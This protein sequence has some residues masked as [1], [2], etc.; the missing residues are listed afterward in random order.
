VPQGRCLRQSEGGPVGLAPSDC[1]GRLS[2]RWI[3]R[4]PKISP[5]CC[6]AAR[7]VPARVALPWCSPASLSAWSQPRG[8]SSMASRSAVARKCCRCWCFRPAN[9]PMGYSRWLTVASPRSETRMRD[10]WHII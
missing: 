1:W 7:R 10:T 6:T 5:R 8:S 4:A 9:P 3:S 2:S